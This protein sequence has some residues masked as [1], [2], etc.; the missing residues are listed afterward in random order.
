MARIRLNKVS[1]LLARPKSKTKTAIVVQQRVGK[2][3]LRFSTGISVYPKNWNENSQ[4]LKRNTSDEVAVNTR[5]TRIE[6]DLNSIF[7]DL[8]NNHIEPTRERVKSRYDALI[9][10]DAT[11]GDKSFLDYVEDWIKEVNV[12]EG[13]KKTYRT[14]KRHLKEF[15][16]K[17]GRTLTF[18]GMD[19]SFV[20]EFRRYLLEV[21]QLNKNTTGKVEKVWKTFMGWAVDRGLTTNEYFRRVPKIKVERSEPLRLEE[22]ELK[23]LEKVDLSNSDRLN[24]ARN[25][26]LLLCFTGMRFG[27]L[28][29]FLE[30][31]TRDRKGH[32]NGFTYTQEKTGKLVTTPLLPVTL[33]ILN[34][35][36]S[37]I[38]N[39]KLNLYIKEVAK[40]AELNRAVSHNGK[41]VSVFETLSTHWGKRT[42][43]SI[44]A[45]KGLSKEDVRAAVGNTSRTID[46]HY[47]SLDRE[48][49][50]QKFQVAF[51]T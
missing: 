20:N 41:N 44:A 42:F 36:P 30:W 35:V 24:N 47:L 11:T 29:K 18:D 33:K 6:S 1:F 26:F 38:T 22:S 7:I 2:M 45:D 4:R 8:Q 37:L 19:Q 28:P 15:S 16:E 34:N 27:D 46:E 50:M 48:K 40:L 25:L 23:Q 12:E 49:S 51:D 5:L 9:S 17:R 3:R 31:A 13:T 14:M 21:A 43:I 39:Q 10:R 32:E